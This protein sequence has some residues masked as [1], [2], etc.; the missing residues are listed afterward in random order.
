MHK[1]LSILLTLITTVLCMAHPEPTP[2][3]A[4]LG[5]LQ[6]QTSHRSLPF[7]GEKPETKTQK[8][9]DYYTLTQIYEYSKSL[10]RYFQD[11]LSTNSYMKYELKVNR[12]NLLLLAVPDMY[13]LMKEDRH[14]IYEEYSRFKRLPS[15]KFETNRNVY[16]SILPHH[17]IDAEEMAI[18][19][20]PSLYTEVMFGKDMIL[21]PFVKANKKYYRFTFE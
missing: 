14:F 15:G 5:S 18:Y 20:A 10:P 19:Y 3:R 21:S 6:S 12:R 11:T 7:S 8:Y 1:P 4:I 13:D 16:K 9:R 2:K 17:S